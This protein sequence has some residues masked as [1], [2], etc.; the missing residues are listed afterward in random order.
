MDPD[1]MQHW[2][3]TSKQAMGSENYKTSHDIQKVSENFNNL[4]EDVQRT[5][6]GTWNVIAG[7]SEF[8][9]GATIS[10]GT[11][12]FLSGVG[13][14]VALHGGYKFAEGAHQIAN[15]LSGEESSSDPK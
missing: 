9:S 13:I 3:A 11:T 10:I 15:V 7:V 1:G 6:N 12:G 8:L 2:P 4:P 14:A 5:A